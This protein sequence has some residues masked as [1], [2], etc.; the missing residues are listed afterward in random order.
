MTTTGLSHRTFLYNGERG[1][2]G[3]VLNQH[4]SSLKPFTSKKQVGNVDVFLHLASKTV[5]EVE[6]SFDLEYLKEVVKYCKSNQIKNLV[7]FSSVSVYGSVN[8]LLVDETYEAS[9]LQGYAK[10]KWLCEEYLKALDGLNILIL[11]L[12]AVLTQKSDTYIVRLLQQLQNDEP[13]SLKNY[14]QDFN[15]FIGVEDIASFLKEYA[16]KEKFEVL[17]FASSPE[18]TLLDV[19]KYLKKITSSASEIVLE[20]EKS[21]FFN[22]SIEKLTKKYEFKPSCYKESLKNWIELRDEK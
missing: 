20:D 4:I 5:Q 8:E 16:F 15:A 11:R 9:S 10:S 13:I 21:N 22:L 18:Q 12:P 17:N 7:Y 2:V 6:E 3:R 1:Y 19:V 14:D